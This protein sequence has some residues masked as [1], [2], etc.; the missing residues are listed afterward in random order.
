MRL[1]QDGNECEMG[2]ADIE[3]QPA[4]EN[5]RPEPHRAGLIIRD[6]GGVLMVSEFAGEE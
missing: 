1:I 6:N 2:M 4:I 5:L 3:I